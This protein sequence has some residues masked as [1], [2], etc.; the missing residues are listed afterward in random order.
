MLMK[1]AAPSAISIHALHEESDDGSTSV[2]PTP[3]TFQ[4]TLS[5]RRATHSFGRH[6]HFLTISI[7]ALHEE[8]DRC[9]SARTKQGRDFNPRSP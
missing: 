8:S 9:H 1:L 7:H 5:M 4:S 6:A 2:S 3:P